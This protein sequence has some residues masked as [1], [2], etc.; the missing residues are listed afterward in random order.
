MILLA[1]AGNC[2]G[3]VV[4]PGWDHNIIAVA[5]VDFWGRKWKGSSHGSKVDVAA[6]GENVFVA[7]RTAPSDLNKTLVEAAQGTSFAVAITAG[8][9]ALWL[10][11]HSKQAVRAKANM[12]GVSVLELFRAALRQTATAPPDWDLAEL[13]TGIVDAD[14]LLGLALQDIRIP[15]PTELAIPRARSWETISIGAGT[16]PKPA[17]LAFRHTSARIRGALRRWSCRSRHVRVSRWLRP[18]AG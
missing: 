12:R 18:C 17:T 9:A 14:K 6:P 8:C 7:R 13:G 16:G 15:V 4:Y 11:R 3:W 2:V 10:A 5:A 1:A